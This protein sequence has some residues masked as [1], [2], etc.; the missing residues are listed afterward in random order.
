MKLIIIISLAL[1]QISCA[2]SRNGDL[3]NDSTIVQQKQ[4]D[5]KY[6]HD[7]GQLS[8]KIEPWEDRIRNVICYNRQGEESYRFQEVRRSYSVRAELKFGSTGALKTVI[9]TSNPGASR[10]LTKS[11]ISFDEENTPLWMTVEETPRSSEF[12]IN[13]AKSYYWNQ[14]TKKWMTQ[15]SQIDQKT[16]KH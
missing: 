4:V 11:T 8:V 9:T 14:K 1:L 6:Y 16:P 5:N 10:T 12:L 7:N 3:K 13:G 15:E 2:T